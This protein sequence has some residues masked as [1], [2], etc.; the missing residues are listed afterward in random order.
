MK[1]IPLGF[2]KYA[3]VDDTDYDWLSQYIWK[4]TL[5]GHAINDIEKT[6]LCKI[7][8]SPVFQMA[9]L[10]L[11]LEEGD[12]RECDHI[13]HIPYDNQRCNLRI[14]THAENQHNRGLTKRH[15][16]SQFK[17]VHWNRRVKKWRAQ[18]VIDRKQK[19]LGYFSKEKYAAQAYNLAAKRYFGKFAFLN[20]IA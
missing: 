8:F 7:P 3:L 9:R 15:T 6:L 2:G 5:F 20:K 19:F 1:K 11:G 12:N 13:N 10:I 4:T 16:T 14:C 17:G 18:I